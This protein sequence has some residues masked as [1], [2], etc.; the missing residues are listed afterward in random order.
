MFE[1]ATAMSLSSFNV[2]T[3]VPDAELWIKICGMTTPEGVDA[4]VAAGVDA[5]GFVFYAPSKRCLKPA[6]AARLAARVPAGILKF[7]VMLHPL[8][9]EV[10]EM[11]AGFHPDV[12]QTDHED[13]LQLA[14]PQDIAT[15]PVFRSGG[16]LPQALPS[17]LLFEGP[18]SGAG[19]TADWSGALSLVTRCEL[20][21][22]GGLHPGN[23]GQ[24]VALVQP[25]GVD[26]ST[27]VEQAPGIKDP[28]RIHEF[29][30]VARA[31]HVRQSLQ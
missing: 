17:R 18:V 10:D 9:S 12:L 16:G 23:V 28:Q 7:A 24:A 2:R 11:L 5:V 8:Q 6:D 3:A 13:L 26:V 14:I 29:V 22:A 30:R 27:G 4:A 19:A 15:L 25:F 31:A 21:L 20:I 1:H